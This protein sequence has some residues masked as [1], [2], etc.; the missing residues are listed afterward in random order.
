MPR[1][2]REPGI[3][4]NELKKGKSSFRI[5]VSMR[6]PHTGK[7]EPYYETVNGTYSDAKR[8]KRE[9]LDQVDKGL[10]VHR[11]LTLSEWAELWLRGYSYRWRNKTK[12]RYLEII[13]K[14]ILPYRGDVE[15]SQLSPASIA[16]LY[17]VLRREGKIVRNRQGEVTGTSGLSERTILHV[18]RA[19]SLML[20]WAV[21]DDKLLK[22]P[23]DKVVTP[24]PLKRRWTNA[25]GESQGNMLALSKEQLRKL[26]TSFSGTIYFPIV[27]LAAATGMRRGEILGLRWQDVDLTKRVLKVWNALEETKLE[28]VRLDRPKN[29]ASERTIGIDETTVRV[30]KEHKAREESA[31]RALGLKLSSEHPVFRVQVHNEVSAESFFKFVRPSTV[32]GAFINVARGIEGDPI[33]KSMRFHDLRHTHASLLIDAGVPVTDVSQRLGHSDPAITL[34]V[35]SHFFKN[36]E[37]RILRV[38]EG[39]MGQALLG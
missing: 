35:Y 21:N 19:L 12:E 33:F 16:D 4:E 37:E 18:H 24:K 17:S 28:G 5:K 34:S 15:L 6:N 23:C 10:S 26:V 31:A 25:S 39:I 1:K 2:T 11:K 30:L 22:N 3:Y 8:R 27:V 20:K 32:T 7:A 9:L 29:R 14:H 13:N 36:S 38:T